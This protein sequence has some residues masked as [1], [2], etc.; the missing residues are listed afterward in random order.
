MPKNIDITPLVK[1]GLQDYPLAYFDWLYCTYLLLELQ[2]SEAEK[3][4]LKEQSSRYFANKLLTLCNQTRLTH[5]KHYT[6]PIAKLLKAQLCQTKVHEKLTRSLLN[7]TMTTHI[8]TSLLKNINRPEAYH[9]AFYFFIK[10]E[11]ITAKL[12]TL[13]AELALPSVEKI[14]LEEHIHAQSHSLSLRDKQVMA[15]V[16]IIYIGLLVAMCLELINQAI[17]LMHTEEISDK[18]DRLAILMAIGFVIV[19]FTAI[20]HFAN[21][22]QNKQYSKINR[23]IIDSFKEAVNEADFDTQA[24]A[25]LFTPNNAL[26]LSLGMP[27]ISPQPNPRK[28]AP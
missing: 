27:E 13:I 28:T 20:A 17:K 21:K 9:I 5:S 25:R 14:K 12:T 10:P 16:S 24:P 23:H 15:T 22:H 19:L 6:D 3:E 2:T 4:T 7:Y 1:Q 18:I 8:H 26:R 11:N